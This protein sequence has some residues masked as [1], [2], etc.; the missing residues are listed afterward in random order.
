MASDHSQGERMPRRN[1]FGP[2]CLA[3]LVSLGLSRA[4]RAQGTAPPDSSVTGVGM[5]TIERAPNLLRM[6]IEL[7]VEG[8]DM[9]DALAKLHAKE[10]AA[11]KK[12]IAL[13]A[14][15]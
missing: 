10:E 15:E 3:L 1:R 13:A 9:K 7:K 2:P 12:V 11:R 8:S 14:S 5:M 6:Q 4:V